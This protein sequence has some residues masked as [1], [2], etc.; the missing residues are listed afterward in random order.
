SYLPNYPYAVWDSA[1]LNKT[2]YAKRTPSLNPCEGKSLLEC[3]PKSI[4]IKGNYMLI[5]RAKNGICDVLFQGSALAINLNDSKALN[6]DN[7]GLDSMEIIVLKPQW[8]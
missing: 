6:K 8:H 7:L 3:L 1:A 2:K 4:E 5:L